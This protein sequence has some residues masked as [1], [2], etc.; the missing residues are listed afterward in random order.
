M[1]IALDPQQTFGLVLDFYSKLAEGE[2]P[3]LLCRYLSSRDQQ[4]YGQALAAVELAYKEA[5]TATPPALFKLGA[6]LRPA[7]APVIVGWRNFNAGAGDARPFDLAQLDTRLTDEELWEVAYRLK[8]ASG[9][10][11]MELKK[12]TSQSRSDTAAASASVPAPA[13]ATNPANPAPCG[14]TE[15]SADVAAEPAATPATAGASN[16]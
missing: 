6:A 5:V 1:L 9:L 7:F 10:A 3:T 14:S 13:A 11:E 2:Q 8:Q 16:G 4:A 15:S 12:S